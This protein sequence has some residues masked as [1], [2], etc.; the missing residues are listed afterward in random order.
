MKT[1][2]NLVALVML[3]VWTNFCFYASI[4]SVDEPG[5]ISE[6]FMWIGILQMIVGATGC[7]LVIIDMVK[8]LRNK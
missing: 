6:I 3:G 8:K 5:N 2:I 1:A 4:K 7:V